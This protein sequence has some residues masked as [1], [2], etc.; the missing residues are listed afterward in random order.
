M[1]TDAA[2]ELYLT[3]KSYDQGA[4]SKQV[5]RCVPSQQAL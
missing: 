3:F 2:H 1:D 5:R 4:K